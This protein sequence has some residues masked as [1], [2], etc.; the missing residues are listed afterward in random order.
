MSL[1]ASFTIGPRDEKAP[2]SSSDAEV[3]VQNTSTSGLSTIRLSFSGQ[4]NEGARDQQPPTRY[5]TDDNSVAA[6]EL[7]IFPPIKEKA[8]RRCIRVSPFQPMAHQRRMPRQ[9]TISPLRVHEIEMEQKASV[10]H[11]STDGFYPSSTKRPP[12]REVRIPMSSPSFDYTLSSPTSAST[13]TDYKA[14]YIQ[15]QK[16]LKALQK[17]QERT[18]GEN[19]LLRSRI[20]TLMKRNQE[21]KPNDGRY[22][23][24]QQVSPRSSHAMHPISSSFRFSGESKID[25]ADEVV[26]TKQQMRAPTVVRGQTTSS[27]PL[28]EYHSTKKS[29]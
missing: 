29:I 17:L 2:A 28:P 24:Q 9:G 1:P 4:E 7:A 11:S 13:I 15:S 26:S 22:L 10:H 5:A 20:K 16:E 21:V 12:M 19:H 23:S 8:A 25:I 14:L 3:S 27:F 6:K 18:I